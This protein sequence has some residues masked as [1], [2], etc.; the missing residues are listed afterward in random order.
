MVDESQIKKAIRALKCSKRPNIA[1]M[2]L[3]YKVDR[4]TLS[5]RFNKKTKSRAHRAQYEQRYLTDTQERRIL[6]QINWLSARG[7]HSTPRILRR[8]VEQ[9]LKHTIGKNW[10]GRFQDRHKDTIKSLYL[11]AID[12]E[13]KIADNP[14]IIG[15]F[16]DNVSK[17]KSN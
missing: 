11:K 16:F 17:F 15:K 14:V 13:R 4:S 7:I 5:R 10:V 2:A 1:A 8:T 9:L 12:R 3:K 6:Q